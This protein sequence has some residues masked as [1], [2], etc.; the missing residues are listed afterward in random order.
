MDVELAKIGVT[1]GTGDKVKSTARIIC[2][3]G[4]QT[5]QN[6]AAVQDAWATPYIKKSFKILP[7]NSETEYLGTMASG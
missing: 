3:A 6:A 7:A 4:E 2:Q 5:Y 1:R